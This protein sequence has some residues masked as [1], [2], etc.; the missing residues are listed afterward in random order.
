MIGFI[1]GS[2]LMRCA[3]ASSSIF[4]VDIALDALEGEISSN[5]FAATTLCVSG[6]T[7]VAFVPLGTASRLTRAAT[8]V[9]LRGA[10]IKLVAVGLG[11]AG[12]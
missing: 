3:T 12:G 7:N 9:P 10:D 2:T 4:A 6:V 8:V 5:G 11:V 1:L